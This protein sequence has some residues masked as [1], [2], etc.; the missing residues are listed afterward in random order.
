MEINLTGTGIE[1][2]PSSI[3]KLPM[4][5]TLYLDYCEYL[6]LL[7]DYLLHIVLRLESFPKII[8]PMENLEELHLDGIFIKEIPSSIEKFVVLQRLYLDK[9]KNLV[10]IP[11]NI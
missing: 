3:E 6:V 7:L 10:F 5:Q 8:E 1:K 2:I 9:C 4:L 11:T